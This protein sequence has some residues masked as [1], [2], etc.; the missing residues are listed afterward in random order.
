[1]SSATESPNYAMEMMRWRLSYISREATSPPPS[2]PENDDTELPHER[3]LW[4]PEPDPYQREEYTA[5][6]RKHYGEDWY[7]Q[8]ELML[9]ERNFLKPSVK[10]DHVYLQRQKA[11]RAMEAERDRG[12]MVLNKAKTW[13]ELMAWART[14]YGETWYAHREALPRD[15]QAER[16]ATGSDK[17]QKERKTIARERLVDEIRLEIDERMLAEG[18]SWDDIMAWPPK[19]SE[20]MPS[21]ETAVDPIASPSVSSEDTD[22][23][24]IST[25]PPTPTEFRIQARQGPPLKC[26]PPWRNRDM[27]QEFAFASTNWYWKEWRAVHERYT[28]ALYEEHTKVMANAFRRYRSEREN[29]ECQD[30]STAEWQI[31]KYMDMFAKEDARKKRRIRMRNIDLRQQGWTQEDIDKL[32]QEEA[33]RAKLAWRDYLEHSKIDNSDISGGPKI[34]GKDDDAAGSGPGTQS[35]PQS[36]S[37][38]KAPAS[39]PSSSRQVKDRSRKVRGSRVTKNTKQQQ[40]QQQQQPPRRSP[41]TTRNRRQ[42]S[43]LLPPPPPPP[44]S[45]RKPPRTT[46]VAEPPPPPPSSSLSSSSRTINR[47]KRGAAAAGQPGGNN[48]DN[49]RK[50]PPPPPQQRKTYEKVRSSR[51]LANQAPEYD[52]IFSD[53]GGGGGDR[54]SKKKQQ[55]RASLREGGRGGRGAAATAAT[56]KKGKNPTN[57]VSK[58]KTRR[59]SRR[60]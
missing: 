22:S 59:I 6:G 31:T 42:V 20:I 37:Q 5:W 14:H 13:Q 11:L 24:N 34:P 58:A 3:D 56:A 9:Q 53:R 51:R 21:V 38:S 8:R 50:S 10:E 19:P 12:K 17:R 1:M 43:P 55:P 47:R 23:S 26:P 18:K 44:P 7:E 25:F 41:R 45:T 54:D 33:E 32:D 48:N 35:Q 40:Q 29:Y 39:S 2:Q 46:V 4:T 16:E 60:R 52:G 30:D 27:D 28:Q 57:G 49:K 15:E 36:Q